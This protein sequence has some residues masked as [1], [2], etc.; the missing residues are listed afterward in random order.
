MFVPRTPYSSDASFKARRTFEC[1][2]RTYQPGD[3][4]DRRTAG[5][6]DR[7][8]RQMW[9]N[10]Q[11]EVDSSPPPVVPVKDGKRRAARGT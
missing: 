6:D 9:S 1:E 3:R 5:I 4:F 10:F 2:G 7:R 8:L 11:I